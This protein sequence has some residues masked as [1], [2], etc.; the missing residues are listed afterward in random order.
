ML[1][2]GSRLPQEGALRAAQLP[3]EHG[4]GGRGVDGFLQEAFLQPE[5]SGP[6]GRPAQRADE[7]ARPP[8][9][10]PFRP[11]IYDV[12]KPYLTF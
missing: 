2:R 10:G 9:I 1:A 12:H 11:M 3:A 4:P 6:Q 5:P 7:S 8:F